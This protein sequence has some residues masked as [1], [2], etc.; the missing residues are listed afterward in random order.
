MNANKSKFTPVM[1]YLA[2]N[3]LAF[4]VQTP[5][6]VMNP[7]AQPLDLL[8][9]CW[10]ELQSVQAAANVM[11]SS[12]GDID[13]GDFSALIVHRVYALTEVFECAV[14]QLAAQ[15]KQ[16]ANNAEQACI[17][18][19]TGTGAGADTQ[20]ALTDAENYYATC[21]RLHDEALSS[22]QVAKH[23]AGKIGGAA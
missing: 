7:E 19:C 1:G 16:H 2:Q 18:P 10:G 15:Q 12:F 21:K 23:H 3:W 14:D 13:K 9:W 5:A 8:A 20:R 11:T 6:V 22:L 4:N 17:I